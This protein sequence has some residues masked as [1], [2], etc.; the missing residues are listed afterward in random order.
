M[1]TLHQCQ[2]L[3]TL[4]NI[5]NSNTPSFIV[6]SLQRIRQFDTHVLCKNLPSILP[7]VADILINTKQS[8]VAEAKNTLQFLCTTIHNTDLIPF[9]PTL[10]DCLTNIDKVDSCVHSLA[11]TTFVHSVDAPSLALVLPVLERGLKHKTTAIKRKSCVVIENMC[12]LIDVPNDAYAFVPSI[13]PILETQKDTIS[14]PECRKVASVAFSVVSS[15]ASSITCDASSISNKLVS[16]NLGSDVD[17]ANNILYC[18]RMNIDPHLIFTSVPPGLFDLKDDNNNP[19]S[20]DNAENLCDCNFSLAYGAK[21]LLSNTSLCVKRGRRYGLCGPNGS[22]KS[23]L[24]RAISNNQLD[25]FPDSSELKTIYVEHDI[26]SNNSGLTALE[27]VCTNKNISVSDAFTMLQSYGF[28]DERI[29]SPINNLSGGWKM[30]VALATAMMA[31]ADMLLLDEPTNHLDVANV[32]W[33]ENYLKSLTSVT[34]IVVSHDSG[35]LDSI[36]DYIIHYENLKLAIYK[37]NLSELVKHVPS[38]ASYYSLQESSLQFNFPTPGFLEGVKNKDKALVKLTNVSFGYSANTLNVKGASLQCSLSSRVGVQGPNGA[39]KSTLIKLITGE[40]KASSGTLWRHPNV[41]IA[42]VAQHAFHHIENH[43]DKTANQY[44]QWRF[45]GNIDKESLDKDEYKLSD[46]EQSLLYLPRSIK[47]GEE[48]VTVVF[49][50]IISKRKYKGTD[51]YEFQWKHLSTTSWLDTDSINA[52]GFSKIKAIYDQKQATMQGMVQKALTQKNISDHLAQIGLDNEFSTHSL[53]KGLSGG[54]KV[55]VVIGSAMWY[56]PHIVV[57]DEP[58][59]YLDRDSLSALVLAINSF[60]GG[61]VIVSHNTPFINAT[62]VENW[63]VQDGQLHITGNK[64]KSEKLCHV[65][66]EEEYTDALGN[67][68]K[69]KLPP[70]KLSRKELKARKKLKDAARARGEA[71]SSDDDI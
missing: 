50:K 68:I 47:F 22:G 9:V 70:K 8:C 42:Y 54:Q 64:Y 35:F 2:Q 13:L 40:L 52:H 65:A 49:D 44:M 62:C 21:I 26:D 27:Y 71:V 4:L 31:K 51:E 10:I 25:G 23:T 24:M 12:K 55:K 16:L 33:L 45:A 6:T 1:D 57:L 41:R 15:V 67:T 14:D 37:G 7:V 3:N 18:L 38:A 59:N 29:H 61:V 30:K 5:N 19:Y 69:V 34:S 20:D 63:H 17:L 46:E 43:L 36:C 56:N 60:E 39:G 66:Q 53:M 11:A 32:A 48:L 58:T 28:N